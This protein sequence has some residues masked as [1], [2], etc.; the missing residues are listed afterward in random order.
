MP[1]AINKEATQRFVSS[2]LAQNKR[3]LKNSVP[4]PE[5]VHLKWEKDLK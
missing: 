1:S 5:A 3:K 2:H 4:M